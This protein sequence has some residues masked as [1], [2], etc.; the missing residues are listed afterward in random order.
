MVFRRRALLNKHK[1]KLKTEKAKRVL[2]W[3]PKVTNIQDIISSAWK[4]HQ[5]HPNGY[6]GK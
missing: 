6:S 2:G 3:E 1:T 4:W 5:L